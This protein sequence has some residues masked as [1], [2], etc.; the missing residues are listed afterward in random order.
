MALSGGRTGFTRWQHQQPFGMLKRGSCISQVLKMQ[1][2]R[3]TVSL[4]IRDGICASPTL[5]PHFCSWLGAAAVGSSCWHVGGLPPPGALFAR[6]G[7]PTVHA[8]RPP[9]LNPRPSQGPCRFMVTPDQPWDNGTGA[10]MCV[11]CGD[12]LWTPCVCAFIV[13]S[14]KQH[15]VS[16]EV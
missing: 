11:A 13:S 10:I 16:Q 4:N 7:S 3:Q 15:N 1:K 5:A 8:R 9:G 6:S 14:T 12:N 2:S